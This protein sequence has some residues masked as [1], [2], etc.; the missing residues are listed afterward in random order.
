MDLKYANSI[1]SLLIAL[2]HN[3]NVGLDHVQEVVDKLGTFG[4]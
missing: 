4:V 1:H 2:L 3:Q